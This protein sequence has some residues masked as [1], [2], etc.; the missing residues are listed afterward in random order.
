MGVAPNQSDHAETL[1]KQFIGSEET[2]DGIW[3]I[4]NVPNFLYG[5]SLTAEAVSAE[6]A[7]SYQV[8]NPSDAYVEAGP[9]FGMTTKW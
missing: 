3:A 1:W 7:T 9:S 8:E 4:R 2:Y 5:A 6:E